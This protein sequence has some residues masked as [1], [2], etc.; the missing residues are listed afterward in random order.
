[1][2]DV[3]RPPENCCLCGD[4][5]VREFSHHGKPISEFPPVCSPCRAERT[6]AIHVVIPKTVDPAELSRRIAPYRDSNPQA[7]AGA[8]Q[9]ALQVWERALQDA[10]HSAKALLRVL[11]E[12]PDEERVAH[13]LMG[14]RLVGDLEAARTPEP[15][16][17]R[18]TGLAPELA[19]RIAEEVPLAEGPPL[20]SGDLSGVLE[21]VRAARQRAQPTADPITLPDGDAP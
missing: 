5:E 8:I 10:A 18:L 14:G 11:A 4:H 16:T 7:V 17:L 21:E 1:M 15:G 6:R 19:R 3:R 2:S 13:E 12:R 20:Q 9:V